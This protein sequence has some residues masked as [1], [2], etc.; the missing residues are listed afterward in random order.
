MDTIAQL[1][2]VDRVYD[3]ARTAI[4]THE[5]APG[6]LADRLNASPQPIQHKLLALDR[7]GFLQRIGCGGSMAAMLDAGFVRY[8]YQLRVPEI[9]CGKPTRTKAPA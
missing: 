5:L 9:E 4:C 6:E 1:R 8:V 2:L 3:T 7:Q